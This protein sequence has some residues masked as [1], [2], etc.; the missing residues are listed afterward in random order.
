[1]RDG[2]KKLHVGDLGRIVTGKTPKTA[3]IENYGGNIPFLT[4]SDDLSTKRVKRTIKTITEKGLSEVKNCLL[5]PHSVCVSCIGSDLGKVVVTTHPTVT[6]QQINSIVP[7]SNFDYNFIYY[8]MTILGETLNHIS[9]TSTAVPIVNKTSFSN[10]TVL[11]PSLPEQRAIA[12]TLACLDDKIE[13]NNK[14]NAN[15]EAQAQAIFKSWFVDFEPFQNGEFVDSELGMIPRGW[16]V[17]KLEELITVKYGKDHK[18]LADGLIPVFGSG[19]IMRYAEKSLYEKESVLIPRKGTLNNVLYINEP[20]WT[21]DTMF[22]SE[23][24]QNNIAKYIYH[25]I[26]NKDLASMNAGSAVPSMTTEILNNIS[27]LVAPDLVFTEF[28]QLLAPLFKLKKHNEVQSRTLTALRDALL[29]KLMSG[30]IE[31]PV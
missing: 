17:G 29:P 9:K 30:E 26:S 14:I 3:I 10:Y 19:G 22:Y 12:A 5:P 4:P 15:L 25:F 24:K 2:W 31:V 27:V 23:M 8:A 7:N 21:V 28:E 20:F 11:V 16:R 6:N 13:L 1:M 18:K